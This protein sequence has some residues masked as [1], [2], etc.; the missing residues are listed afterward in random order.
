VR[1]VDT[2]VGATPRGGRGEKRECSANDT[3]CSWSEEKGKSRGR[4]KKAE[5]VGYRI[6][7]GALQKLFY[8]NQHL[9]GRK[10]RRE[11]EE[12]RKTSS[13]DYFN[14]NKEKKGTEGNGDVGRCP[15]P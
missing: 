15:V 3:V 9:K 7:I 12:M 13:S 11:K 5:K 6:D 4:R 14:F 8:K 1:V 2:F 10:N